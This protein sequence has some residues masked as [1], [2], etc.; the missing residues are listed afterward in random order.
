MNVGSRCLRSY[1]ISQC[2]SQNQRSW[3]LILFAYAGSSGIYIYIIN[4]H[5]YIHIAR[6]R[7]SF[8][9]KKS[10]I[11]GWLSWNPTDRPQGEWWRADASEGSLEWCL[12]RIGIHISYIYIMI[13]ICM[14][15]YIYHI[16]IYH[17][18]IYIQN[19]VFSSSTG[20]DKR[21]GMILLIIDG[22]KY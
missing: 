17:I 8:S 20:V 6:E 5:K 15:I 12:L 1:H 2:C 19:I 3:M 10:P 16:Y 18:Y 11:W 21:N 22:S 9:P 14:Y 7:E 13:C 4:I